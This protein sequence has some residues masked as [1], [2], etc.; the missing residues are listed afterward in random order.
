MNFTKRTLLGMSQKGF[1]EG[2][3]AWVLV[4]S[5]T[6]RIVLLYMQ[7]SN[8]NFP[9]SSNFEEIRWERTE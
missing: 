6:A 7:N 3:G 5:D 9:A 2:G 1:K 4:F 8:C